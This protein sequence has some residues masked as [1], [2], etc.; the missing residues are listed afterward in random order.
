M[1]KAETFEGFIKRERKRLQ[2]ARDKAAGKKAEVERELDAIERELTA[3]EAYDKA[4]GGKAERAPRRAPRRAKGRRG[5]KRQAILDMLRQ[6]P[7]GLKRG[8]MLN[9]MGVKGNKSAEQSVSNALLALTKQSQLGRR[10]GNYRN[11]AATTAVAISTQ[12]VLSCGICV[13]PSVQPLRS[14]VLPA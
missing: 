11:S 10:E 14:E 12:S 2:K 13:G 5:E 7:D 3:I 9:L 1:A 8:E 6:H 4:K